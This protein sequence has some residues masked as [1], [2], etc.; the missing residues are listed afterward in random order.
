MTDERIGGER[1]TRRVSSETWHHEGGMVP[2]KKEEVIAM[3]PAP[4]NLIDDDTSRECE[5][6]HD[7]LPGS[8][9]GVTVNGM[10]PCTGYGVT[11]GDDANGTEVVPWTLYLHEESDHFELDA[12]L[13]EISSI[14]HDQMNV[15]TSVRERAVEPWLLEVTVNHP[16]ILDP[17]YTIDSSTLLMLCRF[18]EFLNDPAPM[19]PG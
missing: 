4:R 7:N 1:R 16:R 15:G 11:A 9:S 2:Q 17:D 6:F 8:L 18:C 19:V 12:G 13:I 3:I 5:W 10:V 14:F